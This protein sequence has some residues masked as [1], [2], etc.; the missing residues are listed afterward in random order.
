MNELRGY[1]SFLLV[2]GLGKNYCFV[3][4]YDKY[5]TFKIILVVFAGLLIFT[6]VSSEEF[7]T[8]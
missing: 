1:G 8:F 2:R 6:C 4:K 3:K 5:L 7:G